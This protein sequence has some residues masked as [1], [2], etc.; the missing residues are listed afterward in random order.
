MI[1]S[2]LEAIMPHILRRGIIISAYFADN[3]GVILRTG[4]GS[5]NQ[6][7]LSCQAA[8]TGKDSHA[9]VTE[10]RG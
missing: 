1:F 6:A 3:K 8:G 9:R 2:I 7:E 5:Y 4:Q 10:C